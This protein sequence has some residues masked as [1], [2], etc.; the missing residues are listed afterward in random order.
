MKKISMA[1]ISKTIKKEYKEAR[2]WCR[3]DWGRYYKMMLDTRDGEIWADVF[4][5]ENSWEEYKSKDIISL[6]CISGQT[7]EEK[8]AAYIADAVQKLKEAGWTISN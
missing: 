7:V 2:Q 3:G 4:L 8:E 1:T 6:S 5:N